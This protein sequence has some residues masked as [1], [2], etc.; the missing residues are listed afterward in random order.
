[1][2]INRHRKTV[3]VAARPGETLA[4]AAPLA[5]IRPDSRAA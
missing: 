3:L 2:S 1:M 5:N 4:G